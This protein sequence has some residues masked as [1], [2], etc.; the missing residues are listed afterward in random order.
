[1]LNAFNLE[2]VRVRK[3]HRVRLLDDDILIDIHNGQLLLQPCGMTKDDVRDLIFKNKIVK[4][5]RQ[6]RSIYGVYFTLINNKNKQT[7]YIHVSEVEGFF[8][9]SYIAKKIKK[10]N[11]HNF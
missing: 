7:H 6:F 5:K 8:H 3:V 4:M 11:V 10:I 2:N 1:M 9:F